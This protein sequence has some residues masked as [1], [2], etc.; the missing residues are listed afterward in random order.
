MALIF[1]LS[2]YE[3]KVTADRKRGRPA[4]T[5][6]WT[7]RVPATR[8]RGPEDIMTKAEGLSAEA[9]AADSV[10]DLWSLFITDEILDQVVQYT[11]V[12]IG[13][14]LE[15]NQYPREYIAKNPYM[16]PVDKVNSPSLTR[17]Q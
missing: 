4:R 14:D 17:T 12:K 8:K 2:R 16:K 7:T 10:M 5:L 11:N 6:K 13:E 9:L 1:V 3:V 15:R